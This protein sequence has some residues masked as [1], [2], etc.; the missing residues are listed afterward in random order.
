MIFL[1]LC[2]CGHP[3]SIKSLGL[4][5]RGFHQTRPVYKNLAP[6][7]GSKW[8]SFEFSQLK[9]TAT[10]LPG[11]FR[12]TRWHG[13]SGPVADT[14]ST[15]SKVKLTNIEILKRLLR[16]VWPKE[17]HAKYKIRVVFAMGLL[18]GSKLLTI[19][20]PFV[21]KEMVDF[22]NKNGKISEFNGSTESFLA[23][24]VITLALGYGAARAGASLCG[25]LRNAIFAR[26]A[27][28][29]VT[30]LATQVF[31]HLHKLDLNFHLNRQTGALSKAIDRGG[32]N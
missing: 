5:S 14:A 26:V 27:Q 4:L 23:L 31:R 3:S 15:N 18:I 13:I 1:S 28:S 7:D 12:S 30:S 29:S 11:L 8:R 10:K 22:L 17:N 19:S 25:E 9:T 32:F 20:V 2:K 16:F 6:K 21:F 24:T